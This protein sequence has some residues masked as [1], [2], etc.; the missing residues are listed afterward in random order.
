MKSTHYYQPVCMCTALCVHVS[1]CMCQPVRYVIYMYIYP[2]ANVYVSTCAI[3]CIHVYKPIS[4]RVWGI[5][6]CRYT[7]KLQVTPNSQYSFLW[8]EG[9]W[10]QGYVHVHVCV[11][12]SWFMNVTKWFPCSPKKDHCTKLHAWITICYCVK[13][14]VTTCAMQSSVEI[15]GLK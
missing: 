12:T 15:S 6:T 13:S 4:K 8:G 14:V 7:V 3:C 9:I 1:M 5:C 10:W 11:R 2:S